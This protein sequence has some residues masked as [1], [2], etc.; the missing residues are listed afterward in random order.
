LELKNLDVSG[1]NSLTGLPESLG[2]LSSLETLSLVDC[3]KLT[4][5]PLSFAFL[6]DT[7]KFAPS[8]SVV[9]PPACTMDEGL[10]AIKAFLLNR[11]HPLKM[12]L[13]ALAARRRRMRHLPPELW[14]LIRDEFLA[15]VD[16]EDEDSDN[17]D[18]DE[19]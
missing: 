6:P 19:R 16:N 13:L 12:L 4:K 9:F 8:Q 3:H 5:L 1:C 7:L 18:D 11:H 2:R 17:D 10:P 15:N 14:M